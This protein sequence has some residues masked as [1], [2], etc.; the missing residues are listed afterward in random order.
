MSAGEYKGCYGEHHSQK[1]FHDTVSV[2]DEDNGG[3]DWI[4]LQDGQ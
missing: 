1:R 3:R 4:N 2:A